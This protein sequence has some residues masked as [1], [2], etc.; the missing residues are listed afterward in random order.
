VNT[1][2]T[3]YRYTGQRQDD[4]LGLYDYNAR[5][6][7]PDIGRFISADTIVEYSRKN[8]LDIQ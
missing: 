2:P 8:Y 3:G 5:Y 7:D 6:Y 1:T 4:T